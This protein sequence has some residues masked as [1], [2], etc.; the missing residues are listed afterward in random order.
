MERKTEHM[1]YEYSEIGRRIRSDDVEEL[2]K[3]LIDRIDCT[4][5]ELD[6]S[7]K[8]L[9]VLE[10]KVR[11]HHRANVMNG[12][13]EKD[14]V[15]LIKGIAAYLGQTMVLNLGARWNKNDFSLWS[16]S[17]IIDRQTKTK[18]GKDIHTGPARG[19]PVVQNVAYFWDMIDTVENSFFNREFKAMKSDYWVEG[20]SKE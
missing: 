11:S 6:Y 15:R 13:Q 19:Y 17:V 7:Q 12:N 18:K 5:S 2:V 16:S 9:E 3:D 8:S 10:E 1:M 14:L 20:I 4:E